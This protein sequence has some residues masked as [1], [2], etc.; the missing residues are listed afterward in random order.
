MSLKLLCIF[1]VS[2]CLLLCCPVC[3][4]SKIS[5]CWF[6]LFCYMGWQMSLWSASLIFC[7]LLGLALCTLFSVIP[8]AQYLASPTAPSHHLV[9]QGIYTW[10]LYLYVLIR[11]NKCLIV[12]HLN[13]YVFR[14]SYLF[15]WCIKHMIKIVQLQLGIDIWISWMSLNCHWPCSQFY[16]KF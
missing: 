7:P 12:L 4:R 3:T 15:L 1:I 14:I 8:T 16:R 13:C 2:K 6:C 11:L 9:L 5:W 10:Q